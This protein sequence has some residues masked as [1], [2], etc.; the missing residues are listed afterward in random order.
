MGLFF[1]WLKGKGSEECI[2]CDGKGRVHIKKKM[3]EPLGFIYIEER[4]QICEGK[5]YING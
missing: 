5:G 2:V 1:N 3:N 4:C